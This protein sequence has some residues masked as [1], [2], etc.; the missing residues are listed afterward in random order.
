M[1]GKVANLLVEVLKAAG[2]S[3]VYGVAGDSLNGVTEALRADG[4]IEW[5][6]AA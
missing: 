5:S 4:A 6:H 1:S 3:R 2:V